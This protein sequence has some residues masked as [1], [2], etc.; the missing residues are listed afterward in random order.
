MKNLKNP[1]LIYVSA[2]CVLFLSWGTGRASDQNLDF[3]ATDLKGA[4][5]NAADL[6]GDVVW[7]DFWETWCGPCLKAFPVLNELRGQFQDRGFEVLGVT[8]HSGT[9]EDVGKVLAKFQHDYPIVVG[10]G[11][12]A[13]RFDVIGYPTYFLVNRKGE[14]VKQYVGEIQ[15]LI[16]EVRADIEELTREAPDRKE[17]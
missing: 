9:V 17:R 8:N 13:E 7:L 11:E 5:F 3:T 15:G 1:L 10:D 12:L 6:L 2:F 16:Q 4:E 14:V